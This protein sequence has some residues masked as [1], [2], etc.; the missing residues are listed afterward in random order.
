MPAHARQPEAAPTLVG[1]AGTRPVHFAASGPHARTERRHYRGSHSPA[2][3]P[4]CPRRQQDAR[5]ATDWKRRVAGPRSRCTDTSRFA[6]LLPGPRRSANASGRT[7]RRI[8]PRLALADTG[9]RETRSRTGADTYAGPL[10]D[11][12]T[13]RRLTGGRQ[14]SRSGSARLR[15]STGGGPRCCPSGGSTAAAAE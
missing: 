14:P 6:S 3:T 2:R 12:G 13:G 4:W 10:R 7:S 8:T 11:P 1:R 5:S 15:E 9:A